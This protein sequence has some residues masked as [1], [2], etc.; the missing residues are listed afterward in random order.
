MT[1]QWKPPSSAPLWVRPQLA[2]VG[3][4]TSAL[5]TIKAFSSRVRHSSTVK[6]NAIQNLNVGCIS[7]HMTTTIIRS[8]LVRKYLFQGSTFLNVHSVYLVK[9]ITVF[10][11][12]SD[13]NGY[14]LLVWKT[15]RGPQVGASAVNL[16]TTTS[17]GH[18]AMNNSGYHVNIVQ[19]ATNRVTPRPRSCLPFGNCLI[20][21]SPSLAGHRLGSGTS[22]RE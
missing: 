20:C 14:S 9:S 11:V 5:D 17:R 3:A 18:M 7:E 16:F 12:P 8:N 6:S 13:E 2:A 1:L 21:C 15:S 10:A 19:L 4:A 22:T